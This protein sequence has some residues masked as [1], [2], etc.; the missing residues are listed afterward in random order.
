MMYRY[1][2]CARKNWNLENKEFSNSFYFPVKEL[3][4]LEN[5]IQVLVLSTAR[6]GKRERERERANVCV[7]ERESDSVCL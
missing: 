4:N 3:E 2:L 6:S 5:N 7:C 1:S